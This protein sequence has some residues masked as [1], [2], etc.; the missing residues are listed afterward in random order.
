MRSRLTRW[1]DALSRGFYAR[2]RAAAQRAHFL[3]RFV[4]FDFSKPVAG[5]EQHRRKWSPLASGQVDPMYYRLYAS[6]SGYQSPD[7]V[8]EDI[9]VNRLLPV[10]NDRSR[11]VIFRDKNLLS[12]FVG[13]EAVPRIFLRNID[14]RWL[15]A[16][17]SPVR[18]VVGLLRRLAGEHEMLIAK[19]AIDS[20]AGK[21]I[22]LLV[23]DGRA[24]RTSGGSEISQKTLLQSYGANF[25]IQER[26]RPSPA[27]PAFGSSALNTVR[28]YTYRS[29][30]DDAIHVVATAYRVGGLD[31]FVDN[32]S[33]GGVAAGVDSRGNL[34]P[35]ALNK[36]GQTQTHINGQDLDA[37]VSIPRYSEFPEFA[38]NTA[39][40][41]PYNRF[42]GLDLVRDSN[43]KMRLIEANVGHIGIGMPQLLGQPLFNAYTDELIAHAALS[44][45]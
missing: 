25:L 32:F 33:A 21:G 39:S 1:V 38:K 41:F 9:Y 6:V 17:F 43:E 19:P 30:A 20:A 37:G 7:F 12:M 40:R 14:G 35:F 2:R 18:D 26:I 13:E 42:L 28:A 31:S 10:L 16:D 34:T 4:G 23:S 5:E 3:K 36:T 15:G 45:R 22:Q 27:T 11:D 29:F 24:F 44:K 8:P